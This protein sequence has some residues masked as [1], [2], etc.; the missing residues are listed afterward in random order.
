MY[1]DEPEIERVVSILIT[2]TE[3]TLSRWFIDHY[4]SPLFTWASAYFK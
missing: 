3:E 1:N 4:I 2:V